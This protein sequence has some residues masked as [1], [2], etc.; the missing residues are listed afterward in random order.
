MEGPPQSPKRVCMVTRISGVAGPASFQ[1]RVVDGLVLRGLEVCYGL[2][3]EAYDVV[4]VIGGTRNLIG[5][6]RARKRGVKVIQR[7]DGLN[8]IHRQ[9][10]TGFRHFM[11][12]ELNNL[13]LRLIRQRFADRLVYQSQFARDWW[14]REHGPTVSPASVVHNAVPLDVFTPRGPGERPAGVYRLLMVE[15]NLAGGYEVG[16][17]WAIEL[18]RRVQQALPEKVELQVAGRVP[19]TVQDRWRSPGVELHWLGLVPPQ[20]I[21]ALDRS[22]HLL[23]AADINPACPNAVIEAMACGT[24][25]VAFDTGA[26]AELVGDDGGRLASFGGD[27]WTLGS[28]DLEALTRAALEVLADQPRFRAGARKRAEVA[29]DLEDMVDGYLAA[30]RSAT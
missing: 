18:A 30:M 27:P 5:L 19:E 7:L 2:E 17:E 12:A 22:A 20:T 6:W 16:L 14:E 26:L 10:R 11:R 3:Q 29:F 21:P 28:P 15:G 24:P 13:L 9:R 8:W 23:Y 25:V 1:R 4:L